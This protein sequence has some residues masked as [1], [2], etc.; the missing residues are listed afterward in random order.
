MCVCVCVCLCVS[1]CGSALV[2]VY[3]FI[4]LYNYKYNYIHLLFRP[5][6]KPYP[7][8]TVQKLKKHYGNELF[9]IGE[10]R[11]AHVFA[12]PRVFP[13]R[14]LPTHAPT[15]VLPTRALPT[16]ELTSQDDDGYPVKVNTYT[17]ADVVL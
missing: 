10:V 9:K 12:P 11:W 14:V 16:F 4:F 2:C 5:C 17:R 1:V 13:T 15:R 8:W 3:V 6:A 7:E